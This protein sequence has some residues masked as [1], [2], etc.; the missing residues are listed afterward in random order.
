M[1]A[2]HQILPLSV[3]QGQ[4]RPTAAKTGHTA[5]PGQEAAKFAL[6]PTKW[7]GGGR[8]IWW[9]PVLTGRVQFARV[10]MMITSS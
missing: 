8:Q 9:D 3:G 6:Q 5:R 2:G 10:Q 4:L 1:V 7:A